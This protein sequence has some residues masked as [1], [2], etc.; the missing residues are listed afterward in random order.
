MFGRDKGRGRSRGGSRGAYNDYIRGRGGKRGRGDNAGNRSTFH[1]TRVQEQHEEASEDEGKISSL[2]SEG[3]AQ[4][5]SS[6]SGDSE[7]EDFQTS[8]VQPYKTLLL[9]LNGNAQRGEP[10]IKKRKLSQGKDKGENEALANKMAQIEEPEEE[11]DSGTE[12][13]ESDVE[14]VEEYNEGDNPFLEHLE[15]NGE[16]LENSIRAVKQNTWSTMRP[17]KAGKWSQTLIFPTVSGSSPDPNLHTI[18]SIQDLVLKKRLRDSAKNKLPSFDRL[19]GS[20]AFSLSHYRDILF[21]QRTLENS[22]TLRKLMCLHALNHVFKTR[23]MII[24][25]NARLA[26]EDIQG[27][28]EHRDQGFTRPK[29]LIVLPTRHSCVDYVN[30]IISLCEP[31]QQENKK[32]FQE[33][34]ASGNNASENKPEDFR[35][36][37]AG[38]DDDMFRLGLKITRKTVKF[39]TQFYNSDI[40]FA[41][42]LGL[43]TALGADDA[44][45]LD[46]D[47]LCSIE[48]V[49]CDQMDA[50]LMQNW[51]HVEYIFEHLNLQP[52][53]AHGCDFSRVRTWYLD[54]N[55]KYL[56]QTVL[57]SAFNFPSLNKLYMHHMLNIEGKVKYSKDEEGAMVDMSLS[58]KQTFS[59]FEFA[60]PVTEPDDRFKYFTTAVVPSL[61]KSSKLGAG[62]CQ[63]VLIYLPTY[64]DF[65]RVRNYL[66]SASEAQDISF[67]SISEYT[68]IR[69][70]ARARSHFLS[71]RHL[72]L[73]Y[74]ERAHHF[75]RYHLKG[76]KRVIM[77]GLP[78]NPIFY[79]EIVEEYLSV[80]ITAGKLDE[81]GA[82]I[83]ALFS[84]LDILKLER[85]VGTGRHM[86]MLKEKSGDTFDFI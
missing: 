59:R 68:S 60:N 45:K 17:T 29:V 79:K 38:N 48:I 75:R 6:E 27:D 42:P 67:G 21:P 71:G 1:S 15:K 51:E 32:R 66:S 14:V 70:V 61:A 41:S 36:L 49:I 86:S 83:R 28:V 82:S 13:P 39:F 84:R 33:N 76:V 72:A 58:L 77:Y 37:F 19:C 8:A 64:T 63:G 54:G 80:S 50:I 56:R 3:D 4:G 11:V 9:S 47:F 52:K 24:K 73:L 57:L 46:H 22:E 62:G 74:T 7:N 34:Y 85:I 81:R 30:T 53:E 12:S 40:I 10:Q 78:E 35:D 23:D 26:R 44:K 55:A 65:V 31:E 5:E 2:E 18:T 69:E 16:N 43:R 25:D 20:L